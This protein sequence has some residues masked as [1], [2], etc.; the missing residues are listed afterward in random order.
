MSAVSGKAQIYILLPTNIAA[1][2]SGVYLLDSGN[3]R[4]MAKQKEPANNNKKKRGRYNT[5][6][7]QA[8]AKCCLLSNIVPLE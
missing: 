2:N 4:R 5:R 6:C 1:H 8:N 7:L 3:Q